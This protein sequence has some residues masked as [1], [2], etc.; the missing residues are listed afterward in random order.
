MGSQ[1]QQQQSTPPPLDGSAL[2]PHLLAH[3]LS[4]TWGGGNEAW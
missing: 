4:L 1:E 2:P 3:V